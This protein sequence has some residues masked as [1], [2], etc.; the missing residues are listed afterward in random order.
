MNK[1]RNFNKKVIITIFLFF[2]F[3]TFVFG[4]V[5]NKFQIIGNERVSK[6]KEVT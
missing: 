2:S 6:G 5:V 3:K 1:M 4:E